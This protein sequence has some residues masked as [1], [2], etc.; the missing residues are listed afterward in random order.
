MSQELQFH[1]KGHILA[2]VYVDGSVALW[3]VP[4]GTL[5]GERKTQA[6]ELYTVDWSPDGGVLATAGL[7]GKITL[8]DPRDLSIIRE[9]DAPEWV[10]RVRFS[11]DGLNLHYAGGVGI[12]AVSGMLEFLALRGRSTRS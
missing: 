11:P 1:P 5:L 9:L 4:G 12:V 6:E 8:W 2:V 7:K 10:I 3:S